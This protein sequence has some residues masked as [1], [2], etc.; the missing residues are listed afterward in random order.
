MTIRQGKLPQENSY[1]RK[2]Y[3]YL[4]HKPAGTELSSGEVA[5]DILS[6]D[7]KDVAAFL[8]HWVDN[9]LFANRIEG[10][11]AFFRLAPERIAPQTTWLPLR[12][13][14]KSQEEI[15][16]GRAARRTKK[17]SE[18]LAQEPAAAAPR[19]EEIE[20]EQV[21][22]FA[23]CGAGELTLYTNQFNEPMT[24]TAKQTLRL[25]EYLLHVGS[26]CEAV[27]SHS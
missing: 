7:P 10:G 15:E 22:E 2:L 16:E 21:F 9:G 11:R 25:R 3:E 5:L 17:P 1:A 27:A 19:T 4:A 26:Y 23:L 20:P 24:L 6:C 13:Q 14:P 12:P 8:G 18:P